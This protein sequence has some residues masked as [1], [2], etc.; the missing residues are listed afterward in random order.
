MRELAEFVSGMICMLAGC[1]AIFQGFRFGVEEGV[2]EMFV[3]LTV[4]L[5]L[6]MLGAAICT[7]G[8]LG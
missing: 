6:M 3:P 8:T 7:G 1:A 2:D 5:I 4:G